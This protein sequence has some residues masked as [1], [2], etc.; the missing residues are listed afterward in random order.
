MTRLKGDPTTAHIPIVVV[1]VVD[2]P[3]LGMAL[4]AMDY[5]VKPVDMKLLISRL[6]AFAPVKERLQV[7]VVDDDAANR[8]RLAH[9]LE[10]AG[11]DVLLAAT[12]MR[13]IALARS[14]NPDLVLLDLVMPEVNGV[15]VVEALRTFESTRSTP[16]L[17]L[18]AP[19]LSE[20][21]KRR[22]SDQVADILSRGKVGSTEIVDHLRAVANQSG[23]R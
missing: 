16:I 2:N 9:A 14:R 20:K 4:G 6:K 19:T 8:E 7:L 17:M 21:D 3:E 15:D 22:I 23:V 10:P 13:G 12:G 5:L 1:S 11:F 18:A